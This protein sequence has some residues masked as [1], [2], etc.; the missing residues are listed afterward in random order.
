MPYKFINCC[1]AGAH[2]RSW[3]I[4]VCITT[5]LLFRDILAKKKLQIITILPVML[6]GHIGAYLA[7]RPLSGNGKCL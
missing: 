3:H 2:L 6:K 7:I 1:S 4:Y 5:S